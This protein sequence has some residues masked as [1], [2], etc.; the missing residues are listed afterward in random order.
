[1]PIFIGAAILL[2]DTVAAVAIFFVLKQREH[3]L[4]YVIPPIILFSGV[5]A[6]GLFAQ[7]EKCSIGQTHF[8]GNRLLG[9]RRGQDLAWISGLDARLGRLENAPSNVRCCHVPI[10]SWRRSAHRGHSQVGLP[11]DLARL[12]VA[13]C[14]RRSRSSGRPAEVARG[15]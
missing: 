10:L 14:D 7:Q 1:M 12:H 15:D 13:G 2:L 6:A 8:V 4:A 3:A 5:L 9:A 11:E